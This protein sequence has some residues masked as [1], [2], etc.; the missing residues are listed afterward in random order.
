M[1]ISLVVAINSI[2]LRVRARCHLL[3][4]VPQD[5][6]TRIR[7]MKRL[8]R[9]LVHSLS[10]LPLVLVRSLVNVDVCVVIVDYYYFTCAGKLGVALSL[11]LVGIHQGLLLR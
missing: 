3:L 5:F 7:D 4:I 1:R 6:L 2:R 11:R 9:F 10:R 8:C